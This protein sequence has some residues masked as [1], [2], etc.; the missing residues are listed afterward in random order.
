MCPQIVSA[1]CTRI[2]LMFLFFRASNTKTGMIRLSDEQI[3]MLLRDLDVQ[4]DSSVASSYAWSRRKYAPMHIHTKHLAS[5]RDAIRRQYPDYVIAFDILFEVSAGVDVALHC[6]YESLGPFRYDR[7]RAMQESHFRSVHFNLTPDGGRL[8]TLPWPML[9]L[10]HH[11]VISRFGLYSALHRV[12]NRLTQPIVRACAHAFTNEV[13]VGN[14]FDNMRLHLVEA[15]APR[16]SYVVRL[17][18]RNCNVS[19]SPSLLHS[20]ASSAPA[21]RTLHSA[22]S[23]HVNEDTDVERVPWS[24][25]REGTSTP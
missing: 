24:R 12:C 19:T 14:V 11:H 1:M 16:V 2:V 13:G 4:D 20:T 3:R 18:R 6:D 17:V 21:S 8:V 15:G 23:R 22:I 7:Y 10:I 25:V 9:S 5:V